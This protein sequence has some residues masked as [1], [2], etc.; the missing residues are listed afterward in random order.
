MGKDEKDLFYSFVVGSLIGAGIALLLAP[1]SGD[2]TR[3]TIK[4]LSKDMKDTVNLTRFVD[5]I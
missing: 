5:R 1:Q 2:K 4:K 3:K